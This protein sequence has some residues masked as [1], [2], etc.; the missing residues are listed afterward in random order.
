M[1]T[2]I[3]EVARRARVSPT[4]VS[5]VVNGTRF[6]SREARGRVE[7]AIDA[8]GYRPNALARSLRCGRSHTLGLV[9]PDSGNPFFAEMGRAVEQDAFEAGYSVILCNTENDR[10]KERHYLGVLARKQVDG[11]VLVAAEERGEALRGLLRSR[12]PVVATDRERPGLALDLVVADH[13]QGGALATRHLLALG[14]RRIACIAGPPGLSPSD[15][16]V[17]GYRRAMEEAGA[18]PP[19]V[20]HGDF[21]AASGSA[22]G[23]ALLALA[24]PPTAVFACND[25]MALGVLRAA[26][27]RG[28]Q[29]PA[30][31]AVVG[32]D[33]IELAPFVTPAL[34]TVAQP[35]REMGRE[36]V[37]LLVN[38]IGD[39]HLPRQREVLPVTLEVRQSCG[40]VAQAARR[41][42]GGATRSS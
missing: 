28:R 29:V 23:R 4:T 34:S 37:K 32:Y 31:L 39:G 6:V 42:E 22:A 1:P 26:A 35:M 5:H 21:H 14:H 20:H 33:D 18:E 3:V 17:A 15:R 30:D 36:V 19:L 40:A 27:E 2:T 8:L 7:L 13:E 16:R 11:I 38:R 41:P 25:L 12:M 24:R 9:L 10:A